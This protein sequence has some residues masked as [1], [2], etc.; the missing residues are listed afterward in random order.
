M[1]DAMIN[2]VADAGHLATGAVDVPATIVEDEAHTESL[3][4]GKVHSPS[5]PTS[6]AARR[7][8]VRSAT[9][10]STASDSP[11]GGNQSGNDTADDEGT[12]DETSLLGG[13]CL[14]HAMPPPCLT[15][16]ASLHASTVVSMQV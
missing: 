15:L 1:P 10:S 14:S 4:E 13:M 3:H 5:S 2:P 12:E 7:P 8:R 16:V 11:S 9:V 6:P